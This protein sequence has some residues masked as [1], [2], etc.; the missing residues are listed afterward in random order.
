MEK[1]LGIRPPDDRR[2]CLQDIHWYDGAFGYFPTYTMGALAAAQLYEAAGKSIPDRDAHVARGDFT[3]LL[4]WL[5]RNVH[6]WGSH[7]DT[8]TVLKKATGKP[9]AEDAFL[10]HI[11]TRYLD[12]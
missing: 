9:L 1:S 2:G 8:D 12:A 6:R 11:R 5:R 10:A 7:H 3:P 4:A